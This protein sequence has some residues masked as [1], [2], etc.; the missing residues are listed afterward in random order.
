MRALIVA[1]AIIVALVA[2]VTLAQTAVAQNYVYDDLKSIADAYKK[3]VQKARA[4]FLDAVKMANSDARKAVMEGIPINQINENTKNSIDEAREN[5][6]DS[7]EKAQSDAR[8]RL[9]K[10]KEM[11]DARSNFADG[12][13]TF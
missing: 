1:S 3:A 12:K 13:R 6:R 5:L 2:S 11:V 4:D 9:F 8:D 10:L 7:L